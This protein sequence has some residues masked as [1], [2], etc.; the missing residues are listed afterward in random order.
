MCS[1]SFHLCYSTR[2]CQLLDWPK[3]R[4]ICSI[5]K[6]DKGA[7]QKCSEEV[8]EHLM[9]QVT[10]NQ[11][12]KVITP[13][14]RDEVETSKREVRTVND[15]DISGGKE[16]CVLTQN[17]IRDQSTIKDD[18]VGELDDRVVD[19]FSKPHRIVGG[20]AVQHGLQRLKVNAS[21]TESESKDTNDISS[22]F[23]YVR[24]A[25]TKQKVKLTFPCTGKQVFEAFSSVTKVPVHELKLIHK[26]KLQTET[27]IVENVS[28]N[29][30]F[31][32]FGEMA[33][34]EEGLDPRDIDLIIKQ[35][36]VERNVAVKALRK[37]NCLMDA[38]FE[39]GNS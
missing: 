22:A 26:G 3:H 31:L 25:K 38:I 28:N 34:D 10:E 6:I 5:F 16:Q 21:S 8:N 1:F 12:K 39:I 4:T 2:N 24:Y 32:A 19:Q 11:T 33:E 30:V 23:V 35:L 14:E 15:A 37:T 13:R 9:E 29:A 36:S 27:S 7:Q 20:S 17:K 18:I